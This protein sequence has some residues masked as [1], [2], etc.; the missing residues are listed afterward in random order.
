[1]NIADILANA[2]IA[3]P[4]GARD[5]VSI[6]CPFHDDKTASCSVHLSKGIYNCFGCG[7]KG[8]AYQLAKAL[9]VSPGDAP[10][11]RAGYGKKYSPPPPIQLRPINPDKMPR[12]HPTFGAPNKQ[13]LWRT[14]AG[15]I[16]A[17]TM[18]FDNTPEGKQMRPLVNT[19]NGYDWRAPPFRLPFNADK[20]AN[21]PDA[22]VIFTEGEKSADAAAAIFAGKAI[23][24]TW[25]FGA[26]A[27]RKTRGFAKFTNGRHVILW[28]DNDQPGIDAMRGIANAAR[29]GAK[30]VL[31]VC[32]PLDGKGDDAADA[33]AAGITIN[34]L[35]R[36]NVSVNVRI[37][38]SK[39][40][41]AAEFL[42][43]GITGNNVLS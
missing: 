14:P 26:N 24:S 11:K 29:D 40:R 19:A 37:Q 10:A 18:R 1:M 32:P 6:R 25:M 9:G 3:I 38:K 8:N 22:P 12:A 30:S 34:K 31:W 13:W 2:G 4:R 5:N 42:L 28:A 15:V 17:A 21:N 27:W 43:L 16:Y 33:L 41:R 7:A 39:L 36:Q 23:S 35:R 20:L